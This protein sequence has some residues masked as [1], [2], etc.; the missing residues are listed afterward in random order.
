M[1]KQPGALPVWALNG[2][3]SAS[4]DAAR[5]EEIEC[6]SRMTPLERVVMALELGL[7][8]RRLGLGAEDAQNAGT[9]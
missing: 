6:I 2:R 7:R 5:L 3:P 8:A 9:H 1:S 4:A